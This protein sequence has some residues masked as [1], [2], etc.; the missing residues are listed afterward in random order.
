[1]RR[2]ALVVG[3]NRGI[4]LAAA[5]ALHT[6]GHRVT[7]THRSG[8][9]PPDLTA[10]P[11]D[12]TEPEAVRRAFADVEAAQGHVEILVVSAGITRDGLL[13]GLRDQD[14]DDVLATNLRG[15]IRVVKHAARCM[16]GARWGRLL[17]ISS[18]VALQGSPGQ[19]HYAASKA[20]LIG[21]ARSL[22]WELGSRGITAN[23]I[24]PGLIDT[25]MTST[26]TERRRADYLRSTPLGRPG[27][28]DEVAAAVR[29]LASEDAAYITGAVLPVSGG[30][31]MG[32]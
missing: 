21:L 5:R 10:V 18:A 16:L 1:M 9:P 19:T 4:G 28:P 2:S 27:T 23:V 7:V 14:V 26:L 6:A 8:P 22:A 29:F 15:A 24:S 20:A 11:C 25:D 3:G 13:P 32:H 31:G 17:L 12:I 30:L